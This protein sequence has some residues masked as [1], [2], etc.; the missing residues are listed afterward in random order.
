MMKGTTKGKGA[1]RKK[2]SAAEA[3]ALKLIPKAILNHVM[4]L[5][6]GGTAGIT[7]PTKWS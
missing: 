6:T 7:T 2:T 4:T 1:P 5:S 3:E